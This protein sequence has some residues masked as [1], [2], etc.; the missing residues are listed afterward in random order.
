[1]KLSAIVAHM[2]AH[3]P[4]FG[5]RISAGIDWDTVAS[6]SKLQHPSAYVIASGD[7]AEP[8]D[9]QNAIRQT[10]ADGFDVVIVLDS[11]DERGQAASDALHDVRAELWRALVGWE[12]GS[13]YDPITY[14][15][16]SLVHISRARVVYRFGFVAEFQLGRSRGT[17]PAETW[18]E[19][20]HDG[21]PPFRGLDVDMDHIDPKDPIHLQPGPDGRVEVRIP[22][23][24]PQE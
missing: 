24:L 8:N 21:R 23:E 20:E 22:I 17:D 11:S 13:E 14:D 1:M 18:Q 5:G 10:I 15:G 4:A 3:C 7:D 19:V 6:S 16:G 12:P 2:R 9:L